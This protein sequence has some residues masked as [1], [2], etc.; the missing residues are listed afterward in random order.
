MHYIRHKKQETHGD[1][2]ET[3]QHDKVCRIY[4]EAPQAILIPNSIYYSLLQNS[5]LYDTEQGVNQ[6]LT[7]S[8]NQKPN[9]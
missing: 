6:P 1:W 8:K 4:F 7:Q 5:I 2:N 3:V 9:D